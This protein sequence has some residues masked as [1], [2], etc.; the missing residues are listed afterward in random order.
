[1]EQFDDTNRGNGLAFPTC[2]NC[3]TNACVSI[4]SKVERMICNN[5]KFGVRWQHRKWS[6]RAQQ[7]STTALLIITSNTAMLHGFTSSID[8]ASTR[9]VT[10]ISPLYLEQ[11]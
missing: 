8:V 7:N 10:C 4:Q 6:T 2:N 3:S 5:G 1:M 11:Q 9:A